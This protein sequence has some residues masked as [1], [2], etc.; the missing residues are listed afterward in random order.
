M[1]SRAQLL[2]AV[3]V[4]AVGAGAAFL[5]LSPK[6][7]EPARE[8]GMTGAQFAGEYNKY[9]TGQAPPGAT[10]YDFP[11]LQAGDI[12]LVRGKVTA[13][14]YDGRNRATMV[15]LEGFETAPALKDG[16]FFAGNLTGKYKAGDMVEMRFHVVRWVMEA[17]GASL[18]GERL[19]ELNGKSRERSP[20][21][22]PASAIRKY[23]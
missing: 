9:Y 15:A 11:S 23:E 21:G 7:P 12:L 13:I 16:L 3:V 20:D 22:I 17:D 10:A 19:D 1:V 6:E 4:L 2:I 18:T 8:V 5:L 14:G